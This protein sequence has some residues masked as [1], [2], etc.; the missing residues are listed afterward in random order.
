[1]LKVDNLL[2]SRQTDIKRLLDFGFIFCE[3]NYVYTAKIAEMQFDLNVYISADWKVSTKVVDCETGESYD[4]FRIPDATGA[5]VGKVRHEYEDILNAIYENCYDKNIFKS[6]YAKQVIQYIQ[7]KYGDSIEFLWAKF[8]GNAIFR[9][10]DNAKWYAALL[11]VC[12]RKLGKD[13][14]GD[15]EIIDVK[16]ESEKINELVDGKKYFFGYHMNKKH[17]ITVCLDGSISIENIF[18]LIDA[19]YILAMKK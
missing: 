14:E 3:D 16:M 12:K 7:L 11:T 8:A 10:K 18:A 13:E 4:L 6:D 17:W 15:V 19:S 2:D 1:M 5:F 9:R